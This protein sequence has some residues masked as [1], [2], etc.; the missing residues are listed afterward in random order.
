MFDTILLLTE[1][2]EQRAFT[3]LLLEHN[4]SLTIVPLL[5]ARDFSRL[6]SRLLQRA[7]LIGFATP[8][9]V[10]PAVIQNLA[11]GAYNFHPGPPAYPGWAPAHFA[12]Y[13]GAAEFGATVHA[14]TARVDSGPIVEAVHFPIP[15][16]IAVEALE[17][18]A[19][20]HLAKLFWQLSR[21]LA[22][23]A[24]P[25]PHCG[26]RRGEKIYSRHMYRAI[27]DIPLDIGKEELDRR[28][29][30][31]GGDHFGIMPTINLHGTQFRA[32]RQ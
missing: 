30:V 4:P 17:G 22:T 12:L 16:G 11:Y 27:C 26:L 7:R 19:Y 28:L 32:V 20:A 10:P 2:T 24:D 25:L 3:P 1:D 6:D 18:L 15:D 8:V 23:Q 13:Q 9:I 21:H 5:S 31:F 29:R 14:M